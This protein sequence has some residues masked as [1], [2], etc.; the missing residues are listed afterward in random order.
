MLK[1]K[2]K[3]SDCSGKPE[4]KRWE[5]TEADGAERGGKA[6]WLRH[7]WPWCREK[8]AGEEEPGRRCGCE[9]TACVEPWKNRT[10][11]GSRLGEET[12]SGT[13]TVEA[14]RLGGFALQDNLGDKWLLLAL[15]AATHWVQDYFSLQEQHFPKGSFQLSATDCGILGATCL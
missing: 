12:M 9:K 13:W 10:N 1:P 5:G 8:A 11:I 6:S 4:S 2:G 3:M 15:I 14:L 7:H